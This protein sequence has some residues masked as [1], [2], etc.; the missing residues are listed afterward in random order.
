M[1]E[2]KQGNASFLDSHKGYCEDCKIDVNTR[3]HLHE[4]PDHVIKGLIAYSKDKLVTMKET[5]DGYCSD[6]GK[7]VDIEEHLGNPATRRHK[8]YGF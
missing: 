4:Y 1:A 8:V 5:T 3:E 7:D 6:C 2:N